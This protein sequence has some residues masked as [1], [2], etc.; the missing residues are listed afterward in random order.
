[1]P[2]KA[3]RLEFDP[4]PQAIAANP[5]EAQMWQGLE[6]RLAAGRRS[7]T[8]NL[9]QATARDSAEKGLAAGSMG[10]YTPPTL[11]EGDSVASAAFNKS[12]VDA[13]QAE[14]QIDIRQVVGEQELLNSED[15]DGY[16]AAVEGAYSGVMKTADP[17]LHGMIKNQVD[18]ISMGASQR[19]SARIYKRERAVQEAALLTNLDQERTDLLNAANDGNAEVLGELSEKYQLSLRNAALPEQDGGLGLSPLKTAELGLTIDKEMDKQVILG[20]FARVM[21]R[22]GLEGGLAFAEN[23]KKLDLADL[24]YE[25]GDLSPKELGVVQNAIE[26]QINQQVILENREAAA[27]KARDK[28]NA[29]MLTDEV[30]R[31]Q[32]EFAVTGSLPERAEDVFAQAAESGDSSNIIDTDVMSWMAKANF[33]NLTPDMQRA[34]IETQEIDLAENYSGGG[35]SLLDALKATH[36][37]QGELIASDPAHYGNVMGLTEEIKGGLN[38]SDTYKQAATNG[39]ILSRQL[40]RPVTGF[41]AEQIDALSV[42]YTKGD[43]NTKAGILREIVS[44]DSNPQVQQATF[45]ALD[46][47]GASPMAFLGGVLLDDPT[48]TNVKTIIAGG[49]IRKNLGKGQFPSNDKFITELDSRIGPVAYNGYGSHARGVADNAIAD[50]YAGLRYKQGLP[51]DDVIDGSLL[52]QAV[53]VATGGMISIDGVK[54]PTPR[55]DVNQDAFNYWR[56]D[57]TAENFV[58]AAVITSRREVNKAPINSAGVFGAKEILAWSDGVATSGGAKVQPGGEVTSFKGAVVNEEFLNNGRATLVATYNPKT[59]Q[60]YN[61]DNPEE[62]KAWR[63]FVETTQADGMV[64]PSYSTVE[65]AVEAEKLIH[66]DMEAANYADAEMAFDIY[67]D[68]GRL[69]PAGPGGEFCVRLENGDYL[70][71]KDG[72]KFTVKY[73]DTPQFSET[74]RREGYIGYGGAGFF[75]IDLLGSGK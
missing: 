11:Q 52:D 51:A 34:I 53:R 49:D 67:K 55:R 7:I 48:G 5:S 31:I 25:P 16:N 75:N 35:Q 38:E 4:S 46:K 14:L 24:G 28:Q 50:A 37:A 54:Y 62:F 73:E 10:A 9:T 61:L 74:S 19:I 2:P 21:D 8:K 20:Q 3:K 26:R 41:P 66:K 65:E 72:S 59:G 68:Q 43:V 27:A 1:M 60:E 45:E 33:H 18:S 63:D 32:K 40:G 6:V 30:D 56:Q 42:A 70:L 13:Y 58:D 47:N 29:K 44:S 22:D 57:L 64:W 69:E 39:E 15:L 71:K 12:A 17:R 23:L 36:K